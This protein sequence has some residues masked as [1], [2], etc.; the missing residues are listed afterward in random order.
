MN[1]LAI[2]PRALGALFYYAPDEEINLATLNSLESL[3][4]AYQWQELESVNNLITSLEQHRYS[5][6]KYN[7]SLLFE[8][9]G[10]LLAPPW[11]SVYQNR[12][13]LVMGD[14]TAAYYQF[15]N[16]VGIDFEIKNQPLDHFG[17]MMW[18]MAL[19][20]EEGNQVALIEFLSVHLLP[21]SSR[22]L[23]LLASN[24]D[25]QFYADLASLAAL[26][27]NQVKEEIGLNIEP[28]KLYK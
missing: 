3:A 1:N 5:A 25:S 20:I 10:S 9:Q 8:G 17:L 2:L 28:I 7:F 11:G 27:L 14:S 13:N 19:L 16:R 6:T 4:H 12:D 15:L 21:W 18:A 24:T 22:Y 26:F 23:E